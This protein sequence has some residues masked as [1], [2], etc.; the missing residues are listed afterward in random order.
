MDTDFSI[1]YFV[2]LKNENGGRIA[3]INVS[4]CFSLLLIRKSNG[5]LIFF[6]ARKFDVSKIFCSLFFSHL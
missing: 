3:S 6:A 4:V 2:A 5:E 1:F